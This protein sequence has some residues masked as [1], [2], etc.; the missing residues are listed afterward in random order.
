MARDLSSGVGALR[1]L[2]YRFRYVESGTFGELV[3]LGSFAW[4]DHYDRVLIADA[5]MAFAI[6]TVYGSG[7]TWL[8]QGDSAEVVW[9]MVDLAP[10]VR[11]TPCSGP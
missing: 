11:S 7:A 8:C 9:A 10:P 3:L 4:P 6:R 5:G 1:L 2:G